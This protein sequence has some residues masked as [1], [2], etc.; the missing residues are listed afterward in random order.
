M[1]EYLTEK[2][3]YQLGMNLALG[4]PSDKQTDG[5][6]AMYLPDQLAGQL[7]HATIRQS[8]GSMIPLLQSEQ[9]LFMPQEKVKQPLAFIAR[10]NVVFTLFGIIVTVFSI[11]RFVSGRKVDR[12]LDHILFGASGLIG[13]F[14]IVLWHIRD[15]GVT[16]WNPTLLYLMP[17]H[18][19]LVFWATRRNAGA[20]RALYFAVAALLILGGMVL[21]NI[22]GWFDVTCPVMLLV[23]CLINYSLYSSPSHQWTRMYSH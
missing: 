14:L 10:P 17:L 19:P 1:N 8:D 3:W 15:D 7:R 2:P 23:R 9:T 5:W 18:I 21:S 4:S 20:F 6:Q 12:W 11:G 16:A 13:W 22:P